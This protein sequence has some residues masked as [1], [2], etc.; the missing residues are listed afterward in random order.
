MQRQKD[1][2][3]DRRLPWVQTQLSLHVLALGGERTEGI[4]RCGVGSRGK[5][6]TVTPKHSATQRLHYPLLLTLCVLEG[7]R[8]KSAIA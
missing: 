5:Q 1:M 6:A 7:W 4:F 8:D 2:F 3:P